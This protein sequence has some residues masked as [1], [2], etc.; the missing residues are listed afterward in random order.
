LLLD[1]RKKDEI[2]GKKDNKEQVQAR[3]EHNLSGFKHT[4]G[5][6]EHK[7]G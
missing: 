6:F 3:F 7:K 2:S 4:Q 5:R 1:G